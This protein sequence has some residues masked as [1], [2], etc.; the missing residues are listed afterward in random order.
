MSIERIKQ[1]PYPE[2]IETIRDVKEYLRR[3]YLALTDDAV[4]RPEDFKNWKDAHLHISDNPPT[5]SDGN[6]GDFWFEF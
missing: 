3:L 1:Y 6:E 2:R 4:E 5:S